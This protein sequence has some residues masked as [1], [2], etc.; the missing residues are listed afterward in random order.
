MFQA[1]QMLYIYVESPLHAG[2]GRGMGAI[3]LP[4]QRERVSGY[5]MVQ[6]SGL[7]GA[8][9]AE[10]EDTTR[11]SDAVNIVFG[12]KQLPDYAGAVSPGDARLLLFPV[13]SLAGVFA[14]V[15]SVNALQRFK[16][17]MQA[18]GQTAP[19]QVPDEPASNVAWVSDPCRVEGGGRVVLEEYAFK[20]EKAHATDIST[21]AE[22]LRDNAL[23]TT[24]EYK[25]WRDKLPEK[26]VVL[27]DDAFRDFTQFATEVA[28]RIKLN[29]DTKT[30]DAQEGALWTEESLPVDTLLYSPVAATATRESDVKKK[31]SAKDLV[32]AKDVLTFVDKLNE[33]RMQL[34]GDE[35]VGRGMVALRFGP[36]NH[37]NGKEASHG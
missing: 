34:G 15:T 10:L 23:P 8:L 32:T 18:I 6:A 29:T 17:E 21:I 19:W 35:T 25:Y 5:P 24:A 12:P 14:W 13:R 16:R 1:A 4:I 27:R 36:V 9:R 28:T 37:L 7:K 26:L 11:D 33:K 3:D 31:R 2:S 20:T 22:W 30:V